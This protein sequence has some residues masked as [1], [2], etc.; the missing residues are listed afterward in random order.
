MENFDDFKLV[1]INKFPEDAKYGEHTIKILEDF[2]FNKDNF[3]I[4]IRNNHLGLVIDPVM[5]NIIN[6]E[7]MTYNVLKGLSIFAVTIGAL[8]FLISFFLNINKLIGIGIAVL[9][10]IINRVGNYKRFKF[11]QNITNRMKEN[12][13]HDDMINGFCEICYWYILGIL[14]FKGRYGVTFARRYPSHA[15]NGRNDFP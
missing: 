7:T 15:L 8:V 11:F 2:W 3:I 6:K 9:G 12:V 10:F 1:V 5:F 13:L 4:G 14:G